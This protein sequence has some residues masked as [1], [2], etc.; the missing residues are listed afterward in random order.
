MGTPGVKGCSTSSNN[1]TEVASTLGIEASRVVIQSEL[2]RTYG[3]YGISIDCRH[4][5][6]LADVMTYRGEVLGITR[7]GIAKMKDSVLMLASFEKTPDHLFD[8]AIHS[9][10]DPV[11]GVSESII[12]GVPIPLG[13]GLFKLQQ[14]LPAVVPAPALGH[15]LQGG[16][17]ATAV[18]A[19][20]KAA[21]TVDADDAAVV[22]AALRMATQHL[23]FGDERKARKR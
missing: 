4:L 8:A 3:S 5:Q 18:A 13:T 20:V 22:V 1:I 16:V 17:A 12:V 11:R 21:A 19:S 10:V 14:A 6:L 2:A 15:R 23:C 7:F 9:R